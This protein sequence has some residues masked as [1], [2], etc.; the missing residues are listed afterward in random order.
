MIKAAASIQYS[1][2]KFGAEIVLR[3][4][5][6]WVQEG[7][8]GKVDRGTTGA[9]NPGFPHGGMCGKG[10][11]SAHRQVRKVEDSLKLSFRLR[12]N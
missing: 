9:K 2:L 12:S 7:S 6:S 5:C 3:F 1:G 4:V 8:G 10:L 11:G